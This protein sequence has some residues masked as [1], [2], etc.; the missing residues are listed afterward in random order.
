MDEVHHISSEVF[1]NALFKIV[2]RYMLGLSATMERKDG[3]TD[4]FKMFL[5]DVV[6]KGAKTEE[7][8]VLVRAIE[9]KTNASIRFRRTRT[10]SGSLTSYKSTTYLRFVILR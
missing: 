4:I 9:F 8:K 5:G 10:R 7:H 3:T 2:T 1:S 6:Y